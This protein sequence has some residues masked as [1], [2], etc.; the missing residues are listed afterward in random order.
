MIINAGTNDANGNVDPNGAGSR[1]ND[2]LNDLWAAA[3]M[4]DT[5]IMVS[6]LIPTT[7]STGSVNRLTINQ[8]Y[9]DVVTQRSGEGRCVYLAE[10]ELDWW[11][12]NADFDPSEA[13]HIHPNVRYFSIRGQRSELRFVNYV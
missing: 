11:D 9:R 1:L 8:K 13:V 10:M 12:F 6:T 7:D 4:A 5:C 2:I 3:G